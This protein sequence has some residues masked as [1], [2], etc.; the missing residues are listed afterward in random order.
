MLKSDSLTYADLA[1]MAQDEAAAE[2]ASLL[3]GVFGNSD[4]N[5][6]PHDMDCRCGA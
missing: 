2:G 6:D 5:G 4:T 3:K 1:R